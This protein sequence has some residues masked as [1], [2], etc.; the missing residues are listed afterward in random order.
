M[1]T[2]STDTMYSEHGGALARIIRLSIPKTIT[3]IPS[4]SVKGQILNR[5]ASN[6][7]ERDSQGFHPQ[8]AMSSVTR[9][10]LHKDVGKILVCVGPLR[11]YILSNEPPTLLRPCHA[12]R[13]E[14]IKRKSQARILLLEQEAGDNY[15][16]TTGTNLMRRT[17]MT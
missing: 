17:V 12:Y 15:N 16:G 1:L 14:A 6:Q 2:N 8:E 13:W 4:F 5:P 7:L 11:R 10:I 9:S 3:W